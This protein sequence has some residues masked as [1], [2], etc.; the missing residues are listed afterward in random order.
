[1]S[2]GDMAQETRDDDRNHDMNQTRHLPTHM[3]EY[4]SL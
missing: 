3:N 1:M 4:G 2:A